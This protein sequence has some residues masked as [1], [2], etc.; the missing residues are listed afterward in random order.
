MYILSGRLRDEFL[1][2]PELVRM[3]EDNAGPVLLLKTTTLSA[4]YLVRSLRI[5]VAVMRVREFLLYGVLFYDG[6]AEEAVRWSLYEEPHEVEALRGLSTRSSVRLAV[7]NEVATCSTSGDCAVSTSASIGA[8]CAGVKP[9]PFSPSG[10]D[11]E[12]TEEANGRLGRLIDGTLPQSEGVFLDLLPP[13][14]WTQINSHFITRSAASGFV[15]LFDDDEG[16]QQ[17]AL[18]HWLVG[19]LAPDGIFRSPQVDERGKPRELTDILLTHRYGSILFESK[20]LSLLSR[21]DLP[22]R[23]RLAQQ[24]IRH[25]RKA[26]R[27]LAGAA[28]NIAAGLRVTDRAGKVVDVNRDQPPHLVILIPDLTLL[29]VSDEVGVPFYRSLMEDRKGLLHILDP[30]ELL[31]IV[32]A[33]SMIAARSQE[34]T[35]MMG[36]DYWLMRRAEQF[37]KTGHPAFHVLL[38]FG[39]ESGSIE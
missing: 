22:S 24:T 16:G 28:R 14:E 31:R 4:K 30:S 38:R 21:P 11:A 25:V 29:A 36:L 2:C 15:S 12:T 18:A 7:F 35:P 5:R 32:Q 33:G 34:T 6:D 27:Q 10:V 39:R 8:L 1:A 19:E 13:S 26:A 17:E 37:V 3:G 20:A 9:Y 23:E